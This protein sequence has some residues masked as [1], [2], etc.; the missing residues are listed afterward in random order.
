LTL[1]ANSNLNKDCTSYDATL[2]DDTLYYRRHAYK[3]R[4]SEYFIRFYPKSEVQDP[5]DQSEEM[6]YRMEIVLGRSLLR[7]YRKN[8]SDIYDK[9][10]VEV[11]EDHLPIARNG[12]K[13]FL[14]LFEND[15]L[16]SLLSDLQIKTDLSRFRNPNRY[17]TAL[18]DAIV[19]GITDI[20]RIR[21]YYGSHVSPIDP[22]SV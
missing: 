18:V 19:T 10:T 1:P 4:K 7:R 17:R 16:E 3:K 20:K 8:Y 13:K 15:L 5:A 21:H 11:L 14:K 2:D 6:I 12:I 22:E 9:N